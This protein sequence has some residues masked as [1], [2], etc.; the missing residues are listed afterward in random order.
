MATHPQTSK[1]KRQET[2]RGRLERATPID[3]HNVSAI[4]FLPC[5]AARARICPRSEEHELLRE[6]R[7]P[8]NHMALTP[9]RNCRFFEPR[10]N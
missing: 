6:T 2:T 7:V 8:G 1:Q 4:L 5:L 9:D 10:I 3:P